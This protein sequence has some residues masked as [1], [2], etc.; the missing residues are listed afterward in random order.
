MTHIATQPADSSDISEILCAIADVM[1][2][3]HLDDLALQKCLNITPDMGG[4]GSAPINEMQS[5]DRHAQIHS[6]LARLLPVL[7]A[8]SGG[9]SCAH[10]HISEVLALKSLSERIVGIQPNR[11]T[12]SRPAG[13]LTLF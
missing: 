8:A 7:A 1:R 13:N 6:D 3:L 4:T 10:H 5:L 9:T 11:K 12:V 2:E